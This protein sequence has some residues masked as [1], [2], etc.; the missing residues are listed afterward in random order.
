[1]PPTEKPPE[2]SPSL[3]QRRVG[4]K[5]IELLTQVR[6]YEL[7][8]PLFG[9]GAAPGS[10]DPVTVIRASEI[11]GHLRFWWRACQ[12][13]RFVKNLA[14][15]K[16]AEDALWGAA[17][18]VK[19]PLPSCVILDVS[20]TRQ[21]K[22]RAPFTVVPGKPDKSGK[23]RPTPRAHEDVSS[24]YISFPLQPTDAEIKSGGIG[25]ET[26][27]VLDN[28]GFQLSVTF[29]EQGEIEN[30]IAAAFW[31]WETF[32]GLGARTRRGFGALRLVSLNNKPITLPSASAVES[33]IAAELKKHVVTGAW[34]DNVPH[35]QNSWTGKVTKP[36]TTSHEAWK[37]LMDKLKYFR[38]YRPGP[39]NHPGRSLWPEADSVRRL[40]GQYLDKTIDGQLRIHQPQHAAG[41]KFPRAV[42]GLP[43]NFHFKDMNRNNPIDPKADPGDTTLIGK[44]YDRL[45]SPLI[46]RPLACINDQSVG[47]A[48][49]LQ[50]C[51]V[52][53]LPEGLMLKGAPD[54][55][56][57]D[58]T[59]EPNEANTIALL[60]GNPDILQAFLSTIK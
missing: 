3:H 17:S 27:C 56:A 8:T 53:N 37:L 60:N 12:G 19:Q 49:V 13:G 36:K 28:V 4:N 39:G 51:A 40:T 22:K 58:A 24:A 55:A 48:V 21:G 32:G 5:T 10:S 23:P 29:P 14:A 25:M 7:I 50:G 31:A 59:L 18:T 43:V 16:R 38:Q 20:V 2:V 15:M 42:F 45:A 44:K 52:S 1:M 46:L 34:P 6:T 35:L 30:D 57:V 41:N 9:G 47:L 11:R 26:K 54:D 33:M